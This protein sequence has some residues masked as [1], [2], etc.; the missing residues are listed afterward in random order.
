MKAT[1]VKPEIKS[2]VNNVQKNTKNTF[3][4]ALDSAP[5][6]LATVTEFGKNFLDSV[7]GSREKAMEAV[8]TT[9]ESLNKKMKERPWAF[10]GGAAVI[11]FATGFLLGRRRSLDS[12]MRAGVMSGVDKIK[13]EI[14][15]NINKVSEHLQ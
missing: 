11:G 12:P 9:Y 1:E 5:E 6:V 14:E 15:K 13:G 7:S 2:K 4:S 8:A 3:E 10:V